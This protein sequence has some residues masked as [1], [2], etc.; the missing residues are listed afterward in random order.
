MCLAV[1]ETAA[2]RFCQ[3]ASNCQTAELQLAAESNGLLEHGK[4]QSDSPLH[5]SP[6]LVKRYH[7]QAILQQT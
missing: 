2:G 3:E 7:E 6:R 4:L 5:S 1:V